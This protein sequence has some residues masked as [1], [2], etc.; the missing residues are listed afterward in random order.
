LHL[1]WSKIQTRWYTIEPAQGQ[2]EWATLDNAMDAAC[3]NG[4]RVM[5]S[6]VAAPGWTQANPLDPNLG[7]APPDDTNAYVGF[8]SALIGSCRP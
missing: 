2:Y 7:E 4:M 1:Y 6:V 8:V 3:K 5:L